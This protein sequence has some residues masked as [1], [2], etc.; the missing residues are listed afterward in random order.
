[1]GKREHQLMWVFREE[2]IQDDLAPECSPIPMKQTSREKRGH[3]GMEAETGVVLGL[4]NPASPKP[5][6][7]ECSPAHTMIPGSGLQYH[8]E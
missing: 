8:R 1:M 7:S 2:L 3:V 4:Q 6:S 5:L